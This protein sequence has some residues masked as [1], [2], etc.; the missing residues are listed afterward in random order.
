METPGNPERR[1]GQAW[2]AAL[3]QEKGTGIRK[4]QQELKMGALRV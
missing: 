2:S 1:K 3:S 4:Q